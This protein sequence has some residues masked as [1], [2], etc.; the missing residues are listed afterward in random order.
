[1]TAYYPVYLNLTGKK[2]VVIGGG[3]IAEDKV[4][5]LQDAKAEVILI[6]PTVTPALQAWAQVGDFEWQQRK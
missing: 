3:P 6:S 1:M 5:K 4:A 2:C